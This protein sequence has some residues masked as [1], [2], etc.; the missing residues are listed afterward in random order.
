M[1]A[2]AQPRRNDGLVSAVMNVV[3][4]QS[5]FPGSMRQLGVGYAATTLRLE[6][7]IDLEIAQVHVE[8]AQ[9]WGQIREGRSYRELLP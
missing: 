6:Y 5:S 7:C 3:V 2:A 8:A 9:D 4:N 1:P